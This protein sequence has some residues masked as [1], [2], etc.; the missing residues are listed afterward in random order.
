MNKTQNSELKIIGYGTFMTQAL[1]SFNGEMDR[2]IYGVSVTLTKAVKVQ[3][4]RRVS[5]KDSPFPYIIPSSNDEFWGL[6]FTT[7]EKGLEQLDYVEGVPS[8][9]TREEVEIDDEKYF[10]YVASE[11]TQR[12]IRLMIEEELPDLWY[13]RVKEVMSLE[14]KEVFPELFN[15]FVTTK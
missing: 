10:I 7:D 13:E 2:V 11:G 6:A 12:R 8:H 5:E 14:A 3:G 15:S 4:Y 9:Y 1:S